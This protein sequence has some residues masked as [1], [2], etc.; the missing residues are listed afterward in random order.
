MFKVIASSV[1]IALLVGSSASGAITRQ[2]QEFEIGLDHS[3][4]LSDGPGT[5]GDMQVGV[6]SNNQGAGQPGG[7]IGIQQQQGLAL[8]VG[9]ARGVCG[10]MEVDQDISGGGPPM[11]SQEQSIGECC[12]EID[13]EANH[14]FVG[15]QALEKDCGPGTVLGVQVVGIRHRQVAGNP[16]GGAGQNSTM[17]GMQVAGA[18]GMGSAEVEGSAMIESVQE[19][20]LN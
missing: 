20:S 12:G 19:Q 16:G 11:G 18:T 7:I 1:A 6:V 17:V 5:V 8:Q 10:R 15:N 13:Q 4:E 14:G 2:L 3:M 9:G